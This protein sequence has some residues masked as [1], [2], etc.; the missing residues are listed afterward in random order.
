MISHQLPPQSRADISKI[1][2]TLDGSLTFKRGLI[3]LNIVTPSDPSLIPATY[4]R[5]HEKAWD[6]SMH[7]PAIYS[8]DGLRGIRKLLDDL[9]KDLHGIRV[10]E[11]RNS[12]SLGVL[13]VIC[14]EISMDL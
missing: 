7:S 2:Q 8:E 10:V 6:R 4:R 5:E 3:L 13:D 9:D 11:S 12:D 14:A 1:K